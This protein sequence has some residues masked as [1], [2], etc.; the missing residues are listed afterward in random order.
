M[1]HT[2]QFEGRKVAVHCHAGL[3]RTGLAIA[4]SLVYTWRM[5]ATEAVATVRKGRPGA[6]QT[7][8]Q[9]LFV[10]VF[11]QYLAYLHCLFPAGQLP[12]GPASSAHSRKSLKGRKGRNGQELE[13]ESAAPPPPPPQDPVT[14]EAIASGGG[15]RVQGQPQK[16]KSVKVIQGV[17]TEV[18]DSGLVVTRHVGEAKS[19]EEE[20]LAKA[21]DMSLPWNKAFQIQ[22]RAF[23][24]EGFVAAPARSYKEALRR[25]QR[26]LHGPERRARL[27]CHQ[28]LQEVAHALAA[29]AAACGPPQQP[30][31]LSGAAAPPSPGPYSPGPISVRAKRR[32]TFHSSAGPTFAAG[33][34]ACL[35]KRPKELVETFANAGPAAAAI[36]TSLMGSMMD[37]ASGT[38]N[39]I[40][41]ANALSQLKAEVNQ[42]CYG[43]I[44]S[45]PAYV[46]LSL[47]ED[48]MLGFKEHVLSDH[49]ISRLQKGDI[50]EQLPVFQ[51]GGSAPSGQLSGH[52]H[53][54]ECYFHAVSN[55]SALSLTPGAG[56]QSD[57]QE[58]AVR[59]AVAL[60]QPLQPADQEVLLLMGAILRHVG[61]ASGHEGFIACHEICEHLATMLLGQRFSDKAR[62]AHAA[63]ARTLWYLSTND[64][65]YQCLLLQKE[66]RVASVCGTTTQTLESL[67]TTLKGLAQGGGMTGTGTMNLRDG[68]RAMPDAET[69]ETPRLLAPPLQR[70]VQPPP[71]VQLQLPSRTPAAMHK[72]VSLG[73][74]DTAP[75]ADAAVP[76][77]D[78]ESPAP[79]AGNAIMAGTPHSE[80]GSAATPPVHQSHALASSPSKNRMAGVVLP[81][82]PRTSS[83]RVDDTAASAG[84]SPPIQQA[85]SSVFSRADSLSGLGSQQQVPLPPISPPRLRQDSGA[86]RDS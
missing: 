71:A 27:Y 44:A 47:V 12:A 74:H 84:P 11:E 69:H 45:A 82:M 18:Y 76:Q 67:G 43:G 2:I 57:E 68:L 49:C 23:R 32:S 51:L 53:P 20:T 75:P 8:A 41:L 24:S 7:R 29:A 86:A 48:W 6:L 9:E 66:T 54:A 26:L 63:V 55:P 17:R 59:L 78:S 14:A 13:A 21:V 31:S 80:A 73:R 4:C 64:V 72:T 58:A 25:Q 81:P 36:F 70:A 85:E 62:A 35:K 65:A 60:L 56:G 46:V 42:G 61:R 28:L 38:A 39:R 40:A 16:I 37:E 50:Q 83:S 79:A 10:Y 15:L 19:K 30:T 77:S 33:V 5:P 3:G 1:D 22:P 34:L 52:L